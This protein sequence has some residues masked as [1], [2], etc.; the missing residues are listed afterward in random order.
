MFFQRRS[1]T[2]RAAFVRFVHDNWAYRPHKPLIVYPEG[3]RNLTERALPLKTGGIQ[4][5]YE[6]SVPV[7]IIITRNKEQVSR[8]VVRTPAG[9]PPLT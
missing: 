8:V 4:A 1:G 3:T 7:Q 9:A 5:A 6:L 2:S